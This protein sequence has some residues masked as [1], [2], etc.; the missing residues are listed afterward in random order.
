LTLAAALLA[1]VPAVVW[2]QSHSYCAVEVGAKG[3]KGRA[4]Q[5]G[6]KGGESSVTTVYSR[7]IN[8]TI[9]A[10]MKDGEFAEPAIA[11]TADAVSLLMK[12]MKAALSDCRPFAVGSSGIAGA[13]NRDALAEAIGQRVEL[14]P[15]EFIGADKEAEYGFISSV[16]KKDWSS[17]VMIDIGSS[18]TKL[19]YRGDMGFRAA[20]IPLG[21]VTLTKRAADGGAD[22][23]KALAGAID[24]GV[25][26]A[27]RELASRSPGIMNKKKIFWIGGAAW[28]TATFMRPDQGARDFVRLDR[29]DV[30]R[31]LASLADKTWTNYKPSGKASAKARQ[32]FSKDSARVVEVFSRDNLMSGVGIFDAFLNDRGVEGQIYFVRNGNWIMGYAATKYADDVWGEDALTE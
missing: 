28:S 21:S 25:R 17:A 22:F 32:V 18:N 5:F 12:E 9:V 2:A 27:L 7:D 13:K 11:E 26:P 1:F 23:A 15:M 10:S 24:S 4:F 14:P 20:D 16:P 19:G 29:T 8:T 6:V 30:K 31:F 3:V